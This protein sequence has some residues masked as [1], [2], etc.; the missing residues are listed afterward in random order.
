MSDEPL[1]KRIDALMKRQGSPRAAGEVPVLTEIVS[2]WRMVML[3]GDPGEV[4]DQYGR[5][6]E[7][8]LVPVVRPLG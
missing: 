4:G 2:D 6:F 3:P 5:T 7:K 8:P 1:G